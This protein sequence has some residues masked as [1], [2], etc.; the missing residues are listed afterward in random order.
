MFQFEDP[1]K[2][3]IIDSNFH[4]QHSAWALF[5]YTTPK[6]GVKEDENQNL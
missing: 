1:P 4:L 2:K 3:D 6:R 5:I